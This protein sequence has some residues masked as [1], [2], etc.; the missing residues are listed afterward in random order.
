MLDPVA[1]TVTTTPGTGLP[2]GSRTVAV[3]VAVL[4]PVLEVIV[5]G[6]VDRVETVAEGLAAL[7]VKPVEVAEVND[8]VVTVR[9]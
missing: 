9:L 7:T 6:D 2:N 8:A 4:E 3:I 5:V 1:A